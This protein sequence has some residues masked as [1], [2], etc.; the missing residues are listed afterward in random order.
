MDLS[1]PEGLTIIPTTTIT[2]SLITTASNANINIIS[3]TNGDGGN[4]IES[5]YPSRRVLRPRTEPRSYAEIESPDIN[6]NNGTE[7]STN[8][9]FESEEDDE[10][11]TPMP[12]VEFKELSA[13]EIW[14][15]ERNLRKLRE[16][17]RNEETKLILLKKIKHSQQVMKENKTPSNL[18]SSHGAQNLSQNFSTGNPLAMLPQALSKGSLTVI[19]TSLAADYKNNSRQSSMHNDQAQCFPLPRGQSLPGGATLTT[20]TSSRAPFIQGKTVLEGRP[21]SNLSITP[22][23]TIT[24]TTGPIMNLKKNQS[25]QLNNSVSIT[26]TASIS[27]SQNSSRMDQSSRMEDNQT[28]AQKQAAA[29]L[30][31][32]K[33]LEKTLLQIPPPKVCTIRL[34]SFI[35]HLHVSIFS[36][37]LQKCI[38]FRIHQ[39]VNLSTYLAWSM[40]LIT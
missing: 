35:K 37:H 36:L 39:T 8:G 30:A 1:I 7:K 2:P 17:L 25:G 29:K 31:L 40:S 12:L 23:V 10:E 28:A 16:E 22:S 34:C 11:D 20:G 13:A 32:R 26:P 24:P 21:S 9:E 33:Q 18:T 15:R 27:I 38:L 19:P 4:Q 3:T 6:F 5:R 14:E